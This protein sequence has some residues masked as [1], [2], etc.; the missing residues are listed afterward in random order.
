MEKITE[1]NYDLEENER[2]FFI[3][4]IIPTYLDV[5]KDNKM[6][7][8]EWPISIRDKIGEYLFS[9]SETPFDFMD[10]DLD[11]LRFYWMEDS[12]CFFEDDPLVCNIIEISLIENRITIRN[13]K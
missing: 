1:I 5:K 7:F 8:E 12:I 9:A 10:I 4:Y 6:Y 2:E 3:E 13:Y 11:L